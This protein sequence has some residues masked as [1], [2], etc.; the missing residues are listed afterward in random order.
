MNPDRNKQIADALG[1][2]TYENWEP[3]QATHYLMANHRRVVLDSV[4]LYESWQEE[5]NNEVYVGTD[6]PDFSLPEWQIKIQEK[7]RKGWKSGEV[8]HR[9]EPETGLHGIEFWLG[10][11]ARCKRT[12]FGEDSQVVY[13]DALIWQAKQKA[14]KG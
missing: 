1:A 13:E 10:M 7:V 14:G 2:Q 11:V 9:Y 3:S 12:V 5:G 6:F 8:I 4:V